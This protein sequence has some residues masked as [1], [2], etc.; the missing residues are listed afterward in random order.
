[1]EMKSEQKDQVVIELL[2]D[3]L[4]T[5]ALNKDGFIGVLLRDFSA[6]GLDEADT[7][8]VLRRLQDN[9]VIQEYRRCF[10][11]TEKEVG[12]SKFYFMETGEEPQFS[13]DPDQA[14][15]EEPAYAIKINESGF[16]AALK[17]KRVIKKNEIIILH[18]DGDGNLYKEP[19]EKYCYP[20]L[21]GQEPLK[22]ILYFV[23]N[24]N[25][26]YTQSTA[27]IALNL[28]KD[29]QRLRAEIGKINRNATVRLG[30]RKSEK[31]IDSKQNSGYRLNPKIKIL[32]E[33]EILTR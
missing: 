17:G 21:K 2:T 28:N 3:Y 26:K 11:F 29:A 10:G 25:T 20:F 4:K 30:L 18:L 23:K 13:D 15:L 16:K 14:D 5:I 22:I 33:K 1:M 9:G 7:R 19:K 12:Q 24:P 31:L 8:L 27:E 6:K 32:A